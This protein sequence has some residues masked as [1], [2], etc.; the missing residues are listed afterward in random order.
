M[1]A[2]LKDWFRIRL[3]VE[4]AR[5]VASFWGPQAVASDSLEDC[6]LL[7]V[8]SSRAKSSPGASRSSQSTSGGGTPTK[9]R[10]PNYTDWCDRGNPSGANTRSENALQ[11]SLADL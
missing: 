2:G 1:W 10:S 3:L 5:P 6:A 7:D 4:A 9:T 11:W 8:I